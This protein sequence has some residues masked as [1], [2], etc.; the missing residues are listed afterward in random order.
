MKI[1]LQGMEDAQKQ[2][3]RIAR[4]TAAM[5]DY[6]AFVGS[7][8]PYAFGIER[9]THRV[10]GKLARRAGGARYLQSAVDEVMSDADHDISE[11]LTKVTAPGRWV[12]KRIGLWARRLARANVPRQK[13][14]LR[15]SIRA[16]VRK[17]SG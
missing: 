4:G 6:K 13:G 8:M 3:E 16:E 11:G 5:G 10:S 1:T 17:G 15:R 14:R 2:M 9:G 7:R 12:L